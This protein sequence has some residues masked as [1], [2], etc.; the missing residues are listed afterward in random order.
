V[1][2]GAPVITGVSRGA[3]SV[4]ATWSAP[5]SDGG[6]PVTGYVLQA[7]TAG[8]RQAGADLQVPPGQLTGSITGLAAGTYTLQVRAT[9]AVGSGPFSARSTGVSPATV[10]GVPTSVTT[11]Q[12]PAAI[13][14]NWVAPAA[15]G[16]APLTGFA[17]QV[18]AP[19]TG[20]ALSTQTA[21]PADTRLSITGLR[22]GTSYR[23]RVQAVN[24]VGSGLW[25]ARTAAV[26]VVTVP[27]APINGTPVRGAAGGALTFMANWTPPAST[28]G[29]PITGYRVRVVR[30]SDG[31]AAATPVSET[32]SAVLPATARS[33]L[34]TVTT[35]AGTSYRFQVEAINALG[36]GPRSARS[37]NV[38]PR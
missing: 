35:P 18:I 17:V 28:G 34:A 3:G 2:P 26:L 37:A 24:A 10:P 23:F 5:A 31:T 20:R 6:S 30:M 25:S 38:V 21:G 8:N 9:N 22:V 15:T 36:P 19:A 12:T 14:V 32:A 4:S 27:G 33:Y 1:V 16:G 11:A 13:T 7:F 29:S